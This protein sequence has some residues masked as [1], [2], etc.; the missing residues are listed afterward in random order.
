[1]PSTRQRALKLRSGNFPIIGREG[2]T[3]LLTQADHARA[4][5]NKLTQSLPPNMYIL[6]PRT[7]KEAHNRPDSL[8]SV[9][10]IP[11]AEFGPLLFTA[12]ILERTSLHEG[13]LRMGFKR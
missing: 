9:L 8:C 6:I 11:F 12:G 1:M 3:D 5:L 10:G 7:W 2:C 4:S 13:L